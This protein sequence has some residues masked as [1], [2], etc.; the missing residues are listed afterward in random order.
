MSPADRVSHALAT[1]ALGAAALAAPAARAQYAYTPLVVPGAQ[2]TYAEGINNAGQIVGGAVFPHEGPF[3]P[4]LYDAGTFTRIGTGPGDATGINAVGQIVFGY[5]TGSYLYAGG[6]F[7]RIDVPG[8]TQTN[9]RGINDAGQIT[10]SYSDR[11][12]RSHGFVYAGGAFTTLDVPGAPYT[13][14]SGINDAGQIVG[15]YQDASGTALGFLYSGGIYRS[16]AA[17]GAVATYADGINAAGQIVGS[18]ET[19]DSGVGYLHGFLYA[20][21]AFTTLDVPGARGTYAFGINDA[22]EIV[23]A[24]VDGGITRGYSTTLALVPEPTSLVL[25]AAGLG[26]VGAATRHC[27]RRRASA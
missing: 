3:S 27:R 18:Y 10:G 1:V 21:G 23:G 4:Y 12:G 2:Y 6:T 17:P 8:A 22:G 24:Y 5:Y 14:M 11:A 26:A 9:A 19:M 15:S 16:F 25:L 7:T 13:S 20:G